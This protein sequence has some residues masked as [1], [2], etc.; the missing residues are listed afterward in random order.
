[1]H[2][3]SNLLNRLKW[4]ER[5]NAPHKDMRSVTLFPFGSSVYLRR[6][7]LGELKMIVEKQ[8]RQ[9][10]KQFGNCIFLK[11]QRF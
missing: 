10:Y 5:S 7:E 1:M 9:K 8:K 2:W 3:S 4:P 11:S 6:A